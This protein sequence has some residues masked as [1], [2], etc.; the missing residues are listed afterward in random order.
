MCRVRSVRPAPVS[1]GRCNIRIASPS[2]PAPQAATIWP[3]LHGFFEVMAWQRHHSLA[4]DVGVA[5]LTQL[6][7]VLVGEPV[8]VQLDEADR[9]P[10]ANP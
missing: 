3:N 7:Q 9:L 4:H 6:A 8:A 2:S 10:P 5:G 1:R